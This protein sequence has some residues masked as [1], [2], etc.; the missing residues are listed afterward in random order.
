[1]YI[2]SYYLQYFHIKRIEKSPCSGQQNFQLAAGAIFAAWIYQS[3][4]LKIVTLYAKLILFNWESF[5][6]ETK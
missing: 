6:M 4:I 5:H 1:M 3:Q 2:F